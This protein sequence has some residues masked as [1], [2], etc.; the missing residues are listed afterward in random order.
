MTASSSLRTGLAWTAVLRWTAQILS[1]A[2]TLLLVRLLSR[3][4][5]GVAG[6]AGTVAMWIIVLADF[7]LGGA[8]VIGEELE[9]TTQRRLHGLAILMGIAAGVLLAA[10]GPAAAV[11]F[12]NGD[13]T[14]VMVVLACCL[15]TD[16]ARVVPGALAARQLKYPLLAKCELVRSLV[17]TLVVLGLA[18]SGFGFWSLAVGQLAGSIVNTLLLWRVHPI[19]P[20]FDPRGIPK[21]VF[22]RARLVLTGSLSWQTYRNV[23]L[24][25]V[26]RFLGT[27]EAGSLSAARSLAYV[28]IEKLVTVITAVS[29]GHLV[30][31]R[32][33]KGR[34]KGLFAT[35]TESTFLAVALPLS[36]LLLTADVAVP[37]ILGDKWVDA[38]NATRWLC[39]STTIWTS[40]MI[41]TQ[42]CHVSEKLRQTSLANLAAV[43]V[44]LVAYFIGVTMGGLT[45]AAAAS[46][47]VVLV[48]SVPTIS[49]ALT[50]S[51][52]SWR[53]FFGFLRS[54]VVASTS[55]AVAVTA[56]K[57]AL[58]PSLPPSAR[59]AILSSAGAAG[60]AVTLWFVPS[61]VLDQVRAWVRMKARVGTH[62]EPAK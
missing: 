29:P 37:L 26:G 5:Y 19:R 57:V 22:G 53:E 6:L 51:G 32:D 1:W 49:G 12:R 11:F 10:L 14:K 46:T 56:V 38:I 58:P 18:L 59:L 28:P 48:V 45:G 17:Q 54:A 9:E 33:D 13:V 40:A 43:P 23:D 20:L 41:A 62:P 61:G 21:T 15:A 4:D 35:L 7:G 34:L 52:T 44:S 36:G 2:V 3:E 8:V 30:A 55:M 25:M 24:W 31:A 16:F 50:V 39:L 27:G 60:A 47:I 42:V